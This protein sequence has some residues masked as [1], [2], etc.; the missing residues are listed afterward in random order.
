[1]KNGK[2]KQ[3]SKEELGKAQKSKKSSTKPKAQN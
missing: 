1:M 3:N 2:A